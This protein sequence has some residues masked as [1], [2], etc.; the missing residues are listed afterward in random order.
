MLK[1]VICF[2]L[3]FSGLFLFGQTTDSINSNLNT[4]HLRISLLTCGVGEQVWETFGHTGIRV[5]DSNRRDD[6]RDVVFN[7]G[8]FDGYDKDFEIKFMKGKLL[9]YLSVYPYNDFLQEYREGNK[10]V[11]EQILLLDKKQNEYFLSLLVENAKPENKYY[12]YDFFFDNC[13]TRIRNIFPKTFEGN[14]VFG[15][16]IAPSSHPSFRDIINEYFYKKHWIR[17]GV[18]LLLGSKIDREMTSSEIMFLPDY[19]SMGIKDAT[20]NKQKVSTDTV[21]LL[22]GSPHEKAGINEP[23]IV[24]CIVFALTLLGFSINKLRILGRIM[25]FL[26]LFITGIMGCVLLI[27]WFG[28]N[29]QTCANN[30]NLLWLLP[31]NLILAFFKPKG[32]NRYALIAILFIVITFF[33]HLFNIQRITILEITPILL[34]LL[35]VYGSIFRNSRMLNIKTIE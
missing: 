15:Q 16:T 17:I 22:S 8:T 20:V 2:C 11:V 6:M 9:Y 12:K 5:I 18:N 28:T 19:L 1:I 26:L 7:Y 3:T 23:F 13:A 14:F 27:M 34:S 32:R 31:T 33:L 25:S 10:S 29:H 21:T 35:L 24:F 30:F 4:S